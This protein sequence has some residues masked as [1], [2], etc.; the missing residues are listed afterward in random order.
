MKIGVITFSE[1]KDNYGQILQAY[2][3]QEYL[4]GVGHEPFLIR[5][6]DIPKQDTTGFKIN[7][8]FTYT[9]K[10][11]EYVKWYL[12]KRRTARQEN[13]YRKAVDF[14]R[15]NF[16]GFINQRITATD[17]YT[18]QSIEKNPPEADAY[19][20]GSDQIWAGD[21]A[22]YL[23]FAPD[24]ALKIAYAPSLGGLT[25]FTPEKEARMKYLIS[26]L[27]RIGMREQS[28]VETCHR[29][30]FKEAV[31]VVDPTLLLSS[32]KYSD[33]AINP[34]NTKPYALVY[35]L[36]SPIKISIDQI[37]RF[38]SS[39]DL[40]L[41]YVASQGRNDRYEKINP[42]I[43]EWLGLIKNAELVITNSFHCVVFAL[44]FHRPLISIPLKDGYKRMNTRIE[45]LLKECNLS[46]RFTNKIESLQRMTTFDFDKFESYKKEQQLFSSRF[47]NI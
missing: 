41:K 46:S 37:A 34:H 38:I 13:E 44:T 21:D 40:D 16:T 25:D 32:E 17:F 29:L 45:E 3:M 47:L 24:K 27:D 2:A 42:T 23:S 8:I 28:G 1:S 30:G 22:Y 43:E 14:E 9:R 39:K 10:L 5:Y 26:R 20:C 12:N 11:P 31:K 35:L 4:K 15:R 6:K 33:I 18:S 19:I 36:G 7:K